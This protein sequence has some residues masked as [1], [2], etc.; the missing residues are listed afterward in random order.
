[1]NIVCLTLYVCLFSVLEIPS[2]DLGAPAYRKIDMESWMPGRVTSEA[3]VNSTGSYGE[4]SSTSN[5]TDYQSRRLNI[6]YMDEKS[7]KLQFAH[8]L[9]GTAIAVPRLL[10]SILEQHQ[11]PDGSVRIPAPLQPFLMGIQS[12]PAKDVF[13]HREE[14]PSTH[15]HAEQAQTGKKGKGHAYSQ[16]LDTQCL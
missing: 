14:I 15:V 13:P 3:G 9:N 10:I 1:V 2:E 4:I 11:Q 12:I 5:C 16:Y 6:R 8:T 7:K